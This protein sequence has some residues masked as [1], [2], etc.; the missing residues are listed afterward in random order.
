MNYDTHAA[1]DVL[2][3]RLRQVECENW[4]PEHDDRHDGGEL[5]RAGTLYYLHGKYGAIHAYRVDTHTPTT[6]GA[7]T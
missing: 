3:E 5:L 1:R 2:A 7:S 6:S 4:S